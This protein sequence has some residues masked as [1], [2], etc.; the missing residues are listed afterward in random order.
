MAKSNNC[1]SS[2]ER[3]TEVVKE[4]ENAIIFGKL[5]PKQRIT[6]DEIVY[7]L[8]VKRHI[9]RSSLKKL[10]KMGVLIHQPYRG[11]SVRF[12]SREEIEKIYEIREMLHRV[13]I[14]RLKTLEDN[15]WIESLERLHLKHKLAIN[16]GN[17]LAIFEANKIFHEHIFA[18]TKNEYIVDMINYSNSL[19]HCI[20]SHALTDE[21][22]LVNALDEHQKMINYI[23][24]KDIESLSEITVS[25]MQPVREFYERKFCSLIYSEEESPFGYN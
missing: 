25:H 1:T 19:T 14:F 2:E 22:L 8:N 4:L 9:A 23:K 17:L 10:E 11:Y 13:S 12:F 15:D 5:L 16:D 20:R 21:Q 3:V 24:N 18:G 6:E 7:G